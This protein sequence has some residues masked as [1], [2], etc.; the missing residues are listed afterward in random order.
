MIVNPLNI[1][2]ARLVNLQ[3]PEIATLKAVGYSDLQVGF[4]F[5]KLVLVISLLG[6]AFGVGLG[7][8]MGEKLLGLY[9]E[10][11]KFPNL[12]FRLDLRA[13]LTAI[14][15]S[16]AAALLGAFGA[17]RNVMRLPPAEAMRPAPPA[18]YRRSILDVLGLS[19]VVGAAVHMIVQLTRFIEDGSR[20]ITRIA[21]VRGLADNQFETTDLL[22]ARMQGK[23][24]SGDLRMELQSTGNIPTF[25]S[26]PYEQGLQ[27]R[28][29]LSGDLW[30]RPVD[31]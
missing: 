18:K 1:V 27:E 3:R 31:G 29:R 6:A 30:R 8:W 10:Y 13:A 17:V 24:P 5:L 14:G 11:F 23:T 28:I 21:E 15:I 25:G 16:F 26:E 9:Q 7:A 2:L 4:Y 12:V 20:R 22:V 19:R